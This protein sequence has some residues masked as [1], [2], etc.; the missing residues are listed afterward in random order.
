MLLKPL[1]KGTHSADMLRR[2]YL[3]LHGGVYMDTG[4][5]LIREL[6]RTRW[7]QLEDR[8]NPRQ[9]CIPWFYDT[10][11]VNYWVAARKCKPLH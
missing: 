7:S 4:I 5:M 2:S 3:Y 11:T 8:N 10:P 9:V 6:D 1:V